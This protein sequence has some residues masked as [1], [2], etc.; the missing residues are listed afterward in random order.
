MPLHTA[1]NPNFCRD[2]SGM[3]LKLGIGNPDTSPEANQ[4]PFTSSLSL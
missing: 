2:K 3:N 4:K 1:A